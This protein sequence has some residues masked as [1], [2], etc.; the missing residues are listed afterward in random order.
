MNFKGLLKRNLIESM[1]DP[2]TILLALCFPVFLLILFFA[3]DKSVD[4]D[5]L[6]FSPAELTPGVV[7]FGYSM[8]MMTEGNLIC[9]DRTSSLFSRFRTLPMRTIDYVIAYALP[10]L[11]MAV[12]QYVVTYAIAF[13]FGLCW[14]PHVFTTF[15]LLFPIA[16]IFVSLG[17]L[18]GFTLNAG[19]LVGIGNG[20]ITVIAILS[21]AWFPV[22][23]VGGAFEIIATVF[24]FYDAVAL[25]RA[26]LQGAEFEWY[27]LYILIAYAVALP[28]L[29][30]FVTARRLKKA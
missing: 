20:L 27:R 25:S 24:P 26:L 4:M 2:V 16:I 29:S 28:T 6:T 3:I 17:M 11:A 7:V 19:Q 1:R 10:F 30:V 22:D 14:T 8:L 5:I 21:G 15:L 18:M 23:V 12:G 13:C 9:A